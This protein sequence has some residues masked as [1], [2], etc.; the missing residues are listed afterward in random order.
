MK[1]KFLLA[2]S[3]MMSFFIGFFNTSCGSD[4]KIVQIPTPTPTSTY[5]PLC[6]TPAITPMPTCYTPT[7]A[8]M[9]TCYTPAPSQ[10]QTYSNGEK[11]ILYQRLSL[12][13]EISQKNTVKD[14]VLKRA[15]EN[16]LNQIDLSDEKNS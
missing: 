6:Y 4:D 13:E 7:V 1:A 3:V 10:T 14:N 8:P 5:R 11:S 15:K 16:I 2:V 12:V 9:P